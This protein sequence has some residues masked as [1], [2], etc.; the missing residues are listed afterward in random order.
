MLLVGLGFRKRVS[1]HN[2]CQTCECVHVQLY[3]FYVQSFGKIGPTEFLLD[4]KGDSI[5]WKM[6][7]KVCKISYLGSRHEFIQNLFSPQCPLVSCSCIWR[8]AVTDVHAQLNNSL[9]SNLFFFTSV[10]SRYQDLI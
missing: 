1:F 7:F 5:L 2:V 9:G 3:H 10:T 8:C 6:F 4:V